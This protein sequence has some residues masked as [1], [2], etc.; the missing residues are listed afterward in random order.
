[1]RIAIRAD[2]GLQMG[3]GHIM[4]TLVLAKELSKKNEVFY[5]CRKTGNEN[6]STEADTYKKLD[7]KYKSGVMKV[8]NEGFKVVLISENNIIEELKK[9]Q[10]DILITDSYDVNEDYFKGT[11]KIF[12]KTAYIDDMN[13]HYF[14][15]DFLINQNVNAQ[16]FKYKTSENAKLLLGSNYVMLR[17][18]FINS[19]NKIINKKIKDILITVG[20]GDPDYITEKLLSFVKNLDYTFH[21]VIGPCFDS[22]EKLRKF[23]SKKVKFY[24]NANMYELMQLCDIGI[25]ACGSTLYELASCGIPT[26]G[27]ITADNQQGM[28]AKMNDL[29]IIINIGW[30]NNLSKNILVESIKSI[31]DNC[32]ERLKMSLK[33]QKII[34]GKG[35]KR[36]SNIIMA[37]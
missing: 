22:I 28:A 29:G 1:M 19:K 5:I 6:T 16:D 18:E 26:I 14:D 36:I 37:Q 8:S 32:S 25:S 12:F 30:H 15:V 33:S 13:L 17:S 2:G 9:I 23:E 20:G 35:P 27:I 10:A 21:I 4:R 31:D 7:E 11:K 24:F 34:D 3:M